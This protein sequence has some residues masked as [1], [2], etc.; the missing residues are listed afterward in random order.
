MQTDFFQSQAVQFNIE[1]LHLY[2]GKIQ[3][4][5]ILKRNQGSQIRHFGMGEIYFFQRIRPV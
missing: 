1:S 5:Q 4:F 3:R 2:S